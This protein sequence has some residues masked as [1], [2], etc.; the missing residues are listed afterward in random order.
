M[1]VNAINNIVGGQPLE[2][3]CKTCPSYSILYMRFGDSYDLYLIV[4]SLDLLSKSL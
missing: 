4:F 1:I 2:P 3:I